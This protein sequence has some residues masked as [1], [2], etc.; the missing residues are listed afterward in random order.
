MAPIIWNETDTTK[1]IELYKSY[2]F[3][4]NKNLP[5]YKDM[6]AR[7][8]AYLDIIKKLNK[9]ISDA[10]VK[11]KI[12]NLRTTYYELQKK[13]VHNF[14]S[15]R[16]PWIQALCSLM[17]LVSQ[18]QKKEEDEAVES[19]EDEGAELEENIISEADEEPE[20]FVVSIKEEYFDEM[21]VR[22][23]AAVADYLEPVEKKP[24]IDLTEEDRKDENL[25]AMTTVA[26]AAA[27]APA[28]CTTESRDFSMVSR[29]RKL[30]EFQLFAN[31][32]AA[33]LRSL[34]LDRALS[35][36]VDIQTLVVKE[37]LK[38]HRE[39]MENS[40]GK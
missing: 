20:T 40:T 7:Q 16:R 17:E 6:Y 36:E 13:N 2:D 12:K 19:T 25:T 22:D 9:P 21:G 30:D 33:Q 3:L 39:Q 32:L 24:K 4:W 27:I 10:D 23:H 35:L 29:Y 8:H 18:T 34:P 28:M 38:L 31:S 37:R 11:K 1:L 15:S 5:L 26:Q 14:K